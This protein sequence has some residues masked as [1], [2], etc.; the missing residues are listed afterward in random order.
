EL[1]GKF[2][3]QYPVFGYQADQHHRSDLAENIPAFAGQPQGKQGTGYRHG[4]RQD[5]DKRIEEALKLGSQDQV[6]QQERQTKGKSG[7]GTAFRKVPGL[8]AEVCWKAVVQHMVGDLVHR[9]D[10][11]AETGTSRRGRC[12]GGRH[13]AVVMEK[14]RRA[15][16]FLNS[17]QVVQL[18][19]F[20][21]PVSD[22]YGRQVKR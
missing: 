19:Q 21:R 12:N 4:Y 7:I 6:Y 13:E 5:D 14:L 8:T 18:D 3:D 2:Y 20:S 10:G 15:A 17:N 11:F 16:V 22:G 1:V 9:A